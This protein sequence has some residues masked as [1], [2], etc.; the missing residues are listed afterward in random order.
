MFNF[1]QGAPIKNNPLEKC[2][3][4]ATVVRIWAKLSDCVHEYSRNLFCEFYWNGWDGSTDA[5]L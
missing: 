3:N 2:C 4:S 1:A 5:A